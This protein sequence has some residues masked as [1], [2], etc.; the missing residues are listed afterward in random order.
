MLIYGKNA[1]AE[2]LQQGQVVRVMLANGVREGTVREVEKLA[3]KAKVPVD[4]VPRIDID[5]AVKTTSHQGIVAELPE[6]EYAGEEAPFQLASARNERLLLVLLDHIQDPRNFGAIIRSAEV[7]GAHGVVTEERRS[8]PLSAVVAKTA[9]GAT[10]HIPLVQVK[11]LARY[12]DEIKER[13]V[14]IYGADPDAKLGPDRI[15]WDRD[16][17]LVIGS[18]G[19]GL[20][21]LIREKCD[22]LIG[23]ES[24]GRLGSLNASVAAGIFLYAIS[25]ARSRT[26]F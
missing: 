10:A 13:N 8:A 22:E 5:Q 18:E 6:L 2:A 7:L 4:R 23:I 21:R 24:Q 14:W 26:D 25:R 3:R 12:M 17:A 19:E 9:A 20:R 15:D 11:N 1:V 16:A